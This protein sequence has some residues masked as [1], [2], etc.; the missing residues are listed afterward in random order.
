MIPKTRPLRT[1]DLGVR[2][3]ILG[4]DFGT[5]AASGGFVHDW[6]VNP[7]SSTPKL[8]CSRT[9]I[10]YEIYCNFAAVLETRVCHPF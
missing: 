6:G 1:Q 3:P 2:N 5:E 7:S 10:Q 8:A 4:T 9:T